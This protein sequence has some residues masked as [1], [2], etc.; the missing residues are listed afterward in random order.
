MRRLWRV[1]C[2]Q[3]E[4]QVRSTWHRDTHLH[5]TSH[6][7]LVLVGP[8]RTLLLKRLPPVNVFRGAEAESGPRS[9]LEVLGS[10]AG[11]W[12]LWDNRGFGK[13]G[14]HLIDRVDH[15]RARLLYVMTPCLPENN[16]R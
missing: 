9:R 8:F 11:L 6:G 1:A 4:A 16:C 3:R 10:P 13:G 15:I 5:S 7:F 12:T 14:C 2:P